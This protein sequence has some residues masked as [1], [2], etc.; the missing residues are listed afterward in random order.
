MLLVRLDLSKVSFWV[1]LLGRFQC[2]VI[3]VFFDETFNPI[4]DARSLNICITQFYRRCRYL[5]ALS[6]V[7]F[8]SRAY[9]FTEYHSA[10]VKIVPIPPRLFRYPQYE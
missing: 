3:L 7:R 10:L 9:P 1:V 5:K 2:F 4:W 8:D 6:L